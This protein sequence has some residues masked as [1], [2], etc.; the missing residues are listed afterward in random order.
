MEHQIAKLIE[1]T[2]GLG[3]VQALRVIQAQRIMERNSRA[4]LPSFLR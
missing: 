2:P 4:P 3:P 1:T